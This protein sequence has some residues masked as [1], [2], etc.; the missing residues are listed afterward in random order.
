MS[1]FLIKKPF[2]KYFY[3]RCTWMARVRSGREIGDR[4]MQGSLAIENLL[5]A[6]FGMYVK[7]ICDASFREIVTGPNRVESCI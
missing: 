2:S 5:Y 1:V 4:K 6:Q 7:W 3:G